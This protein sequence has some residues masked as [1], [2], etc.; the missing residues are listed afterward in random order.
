MRSIAI[1]DLKEHIGERVVGD[2]F[3][4][5]ELF[6]RS[7]EIITEHLISKLSERVEGINFVRVSK[8]PEKTPKLEAL[9]SQLSE[10]VKVLL[11]S[12][13]FDDEE[14][15]LIVAEIMEVIIENLYEQDGLE[16]VD[17]DE[18]LLKRPN[19]CDHSIDVA[20]LATLLAIKSGRFPRLMIE[21]ITLGALLHD[22]GLAVLTNRLQCPP[23][24]IPVR[25]LIEHPVIG[26][27]ILKE[28]D[29]IPESAKKIVLMHH[30]WQQPE[31]SYSM[32]LSMARSYPAEYQGKPLRTENKTLSVGIVQ[33]ADAFVGL[34]TSDPFG[35]NNVLPKK[36]AMEIILKDAEKIYGEAAVLLATYVSPYSVGDR[37]LLTNG[38]YAIIVK[39]TSS[40]LNPIVHY[41][42]K[43][44]L[45]DLRRKPFTHIKN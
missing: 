6:I 40:P 4:G 24:D 21:Q 14:D 45:V 38:K 25:Q 33:V 28:N 37:V 2:I 18:L 8:M 23:E 13:S 29:F 32:E 39:Q 26:Y 35:K 1:K 3:F 34:T 41:E 44:A 7:G 12:Y 19:L 36:E 27:E 16:E 5:G 20:I 15:T 30:I 31:K 17:L 11:G 22:I 10:K 43:D 9:L 42:G